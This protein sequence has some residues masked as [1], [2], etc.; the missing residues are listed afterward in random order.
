MFRVRVQRA[1]APVRTRL[2]ARLRIRA[3]REA[4]RGIVR[5]QLFTVAC[6]ARH[7]VASSEYAHL[8]AVFRVWTPARHFLTV[9]TELFR[10]IGTRHE[11]SALALGATLKSPR[12]RSLGMFHF[13]K[14][15][16]PLRA[17][18]LR[19]RGRGNHFLNMWCS[20]QIIVQ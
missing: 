16:F 15:A 3:A 2:M 4:A 19:H 10:V 11:M 8:R 18:L 5:T 7:I 14:F 17:L 6:I 9:G 12:E 1:R 20:H 13:H